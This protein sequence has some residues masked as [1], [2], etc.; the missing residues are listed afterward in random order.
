MGKREGP[1]QEALPA[2]GRLGESRGSTA[3]HPFL[4]EFR[5]QPE[6]PLVGRLRIDRTASRR[7]SR[8]SPDRR[9]QAHERVS[10]HDPF[11]DRGSVPIS[12]PRPEPE[13]DPGQLHRRGIPVHPVETA[14]EHL[15]PGP[16]EGLGGRL[17]I[18]RLEPRHL[19]GEEVLG[20]G[21]KG[22]A[23]ARGIHDAQIQ[24]GFPSPEPHGFVGRIRVFEKK[25]LDAQ[26]PPDHRLEGRGHEEIH[27][28]A[29]RVVDAP[30]ASAGAP[31][32]SG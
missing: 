16:G 29:I 19:A 20:P 5:K 17:G 3:G 15:G 10:R 30:D 26:S 28:R 21:E 7:L 31:R 14:A 6:G 13:P 8:R 2:V 22:R 27:Q 9:G 18:P 11:R 32:P 24:Q 4:V 1:V 23:A 25:T 12:N